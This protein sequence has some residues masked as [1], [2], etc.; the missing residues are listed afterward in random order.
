MWSYR[1]HGV[2]FLLALVLLV[3]ACGGG[4]ERPP[5][6]TGIAGTVTIGPMC[7]VVQEGTPCPDQ[8]FQATIVI[9]DEDGDEVTEFESAEDGTF[10]LRLPPGRY[11]VVPQSP[12]AGAPPVAAEQEVEV[13]DGQYAHVDIQYD[14]GIR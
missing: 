6:G 11:T 7:P 10:S 2:P 12:N 1:L 4:L 8:P 14:S 13:R 9:L 3:A 5:P